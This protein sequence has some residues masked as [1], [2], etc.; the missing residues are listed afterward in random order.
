MHFLHVYVTLTCW[1]GGGRGP[2][3]VEKRLSTSTT[4]S[5]RYGNQ[6]GLQI[7]TSG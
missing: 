5:W 3:R 2:W 1:G 4:T 6:K 7:G